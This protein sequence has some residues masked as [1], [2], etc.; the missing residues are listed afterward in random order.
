MAAF[1]LNELAFVLSFHHTSVLCIPLEQLSQWWPF[2]TG[3]VF[4]LAPVLGLSKRR[5]WGI[6]IL[7]HLWNFTIE[8]TWLIQSWWC[9]TSYA[10]IRPEIAAY[11]SLFNSRL[12][13]WWVIVFSNFKEEEPT[14]GILDQWYSNEVY[15][16][17]VVLTLLF[18]RSPGGSYWKA[19]WKERISCSLVAFLG[20]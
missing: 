6:I 3:L 12:L 17:K 18:Q 19:K 5:I 11:C 15:F 20:F 13:W 16:K 4:S 1:Q 14:E 2:L 10:P 7:T 9:K 8:V